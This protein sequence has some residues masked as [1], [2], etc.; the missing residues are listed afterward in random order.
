MATTEPAPSNGKPAV[1]RLGTSA[2]QQ[3]IAVVG[4]VWTLRILR[5]IFR[6]KRRYGDFVAEFGVSRAVL[7]DRLAKLVGHGVLVRHVVDGGHPEY[8]LTDSGMDLWPLFLAMWLWET[9]WGTARDPDTWAPDVPRSQVLHT[10]CQHAMRPQLRCVGCQQEVLPFD[11]E[12]VPAAG[13]T[14]SADA[15][16]ASSGF[17]RARKDA[18]VPGAA[19]Q[20]LVRVVGDRW[21]SAVVAAAFSGVRQF[22]GFEQALG[23]GPAQLSERLAEL[24]QIGILRLRSIPGARPEYRLT[25]AGAALFPMIL[26]MLRW[27]S[28]WLWLRPTPFTVRHKPCGQTLVARWHCSHCQQEL[29]RETLRFS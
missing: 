9:D 5:T 23:I 17:R 11:T 28:T 1:F 20:K 22:S 4:D 24:Q 14:A 19:G 16:S 2:A 15:T 29:Q 12:P 10:G 6:H 21:N 26:E 8:R 18:A 27:G 13:A 3:T 7:T 25:R